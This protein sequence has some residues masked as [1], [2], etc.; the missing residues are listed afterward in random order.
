M[1]IVPGSVAHRIYNST[2]AMEVFAC[3]YGLNESFGDQI[4][5]GDL[6]VSGCDDDG[7]VRMVELPDHPFFIATLFVPQVL[8][9]SGNP[10]PL[11]VAY[12][13]AAARLSRPMRPKK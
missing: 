8:S 12:L 9:R 3:N 5:S 7:T 13:Q 11:I 6:R 1:T 2:E 10:H 4:R